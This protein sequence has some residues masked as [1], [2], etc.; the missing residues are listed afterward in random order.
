MSAPTHRQ[1]RSVRVP[2]SNASAEVLP[3]A[4]ADPISKVTV[5][6]SGC[7]RRQFDLAPTEDD[8]GR[9]C[10]DLEKRCV[11]CGRYSHVHLTDHPRSPLPGALDGRWVCECGGFLAEI[12][13]VRGRVTARCRCGED[14]R[15]TGF[16]AM[17]TVLIARH[18]GEF[19]Q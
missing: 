13:A 9:S 5:R 1:P 4:S 16:D 14:V 6:C 17:V 18:G 12:Q 10:L 2:R 11:R 3:A 7:D 15:V 19:S 8:E